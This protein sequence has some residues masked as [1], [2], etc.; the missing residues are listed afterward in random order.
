[1][2]ANHRTVVLAAVLAVL[3]LTS[4]PGD[5]A[6]AVKPDEMLADVALDML[7]RSKEFLME[8][9]N[10][11]GVNIFT[12]AKVK[13]ILDDGVVFTRNGKEESIRGVNSV[14]LAM[15]AKS[16]NDLSEK[17]KGKVAEVY[18]IGDAKEPRKALDAIHEAAELARKI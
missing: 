18:V 3:A 9:L 5:R 13:E 14:I 6:M 4:A 10:G 2:K 15:G 7:P 16:V 12:S 1:M 17:I 11:Y 8:R